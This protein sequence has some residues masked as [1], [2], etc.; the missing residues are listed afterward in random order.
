[1]VQFAKYSMQQSDSALLLIGVELT[2]NEGQIFENKTETCFL[3]V[4]V[5]IRP[6]EQQFFG[7]H[8]GRFLSL[9]ADINES[10]RKNG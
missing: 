9:S 6:K 5:H 8:C 7:L 2:T 10:R 3:F 1:M 4:F